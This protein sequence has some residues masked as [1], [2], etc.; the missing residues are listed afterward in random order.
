MSAVLDADNLF[1][2]ALTP[3]L[4]WG[5]K[6]AFARRA[7]ERYLMV[8]GRVARWLARGLN[9]GSVTTGDPAV[10][11]DLLLAVLSRVH[12][13]GGEGSTAAIRSE[14]LRFINHAVRGHTAA[15][16]SQRDEMSLRPR[17]NVA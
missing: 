3:T 9:D 14:A 13:P 2:G 11:T 17:L 12:V 16:S 6:D 10:A 7:R 5:L 15:A 4:A 8:R 1:A